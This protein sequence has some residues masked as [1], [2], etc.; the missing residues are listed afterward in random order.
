MDSLTKSYREKV[1]ELGSNKEAKKKLL[2][3]VD[4]A[5]AATKK[6]KTQEAVNKA[7]GTARTTTSPKQAQ[8]ET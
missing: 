2:E 4:W 3:I 8:P 6:L 1:A 7:L 5:I